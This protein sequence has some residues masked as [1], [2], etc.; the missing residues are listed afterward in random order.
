MLTINPKDIS[1]RQLHR[2]LLTAI[3]PRPIALA[4]TI[5]KQRNINLSPFSF[6][7]IF[8]SNPPIAIFSPA[9]S[10]RDNTI[11]H[12][13]QNVLEV[14]EVVLNIVN[15][16]MVEQMS[17]AS[18][19]YD[20]GVNEFVKAG[21]TEL[22]SEKV[23]PPRIAEAP[24]TMECLV[25]Q[26]IPLG[27]QGGAGN[28]VIAR[29]VLVHIQEQYLDERQALDTTKLDLVGRMGGSWYCRAN[30]DALFEISKPLR[31]KGI[32][33]DQLPD[34]IRNS[35]TLTGNN[36]GRLGNVEKLP[37]TAAI[38]AIQSDPLIVQT[39]VKYQGNVKKRR[40]ALEVIAKTVL[41]NGQVERALKILLLN[42]WLNQ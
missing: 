28:L 24:V 41:E 21:F 3:A 27:E 19:A 31:S 25:E 10:G 40:T 35:D 17:L 32:G 6:F 20:K 29:I 42:E 13:H 7:N 37:D 15:Y 16:K 14:P 11:K 9:R 23:Q 38:V 1:H 36:L 26:V 30:G 4:S 2:Y 12:T 34:Y 39:L 22:P 8:S 18:T 33:I 5:D